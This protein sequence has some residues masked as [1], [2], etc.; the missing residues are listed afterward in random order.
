[1]RKALVAAFAIAGS[2]ADAIALSKLI[3]T[4]GDYPEEE[5]S[6]IRQACRENDQVF[7]ATGVIERVHNAIGESWAVSVGSGDEIPF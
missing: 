6:L 2:Y 5:K 3:A 4:V 7:N 1:M